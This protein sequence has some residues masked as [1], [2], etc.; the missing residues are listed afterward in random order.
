[1]AKIALV[2][3]STA[4]LTSELIEEFDVHVVPL[5]VNFGDE[6][7]AAHQLTPTEFYRRLASAEA[8]PTTSQ[9]APEDFMNIYNKLLE[10]YDEVISIHLST[11]LSG[12]LN[13]ARV[14]KDALDQA[15]IH[16]VDSRSISLGVA[17]MVQEAARGIREG[18]ASAAIVE[19]VGKV[20]QRT[21]TLFTL[22]TLE[23]L[24]KGGRIGKV[25]GLVGSLLNIK[26]II[27]VNDEGIYVPAGKARSQDRA[28]DCL[29][30]NFKQLANGRAAVQIAVAHGAAREAAQRLQTAMEE[31]FSVKASI[32]TEVGPVIGVHTGPGTVGVAVVFE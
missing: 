28:L 1:M 5:G 14:A 19:A 16:L 17:V 11:A 24:Q 21:E 32:F 20:R 18:L 9:P 10:K 31:A 4:D 12:T 7:F 13:A 30:K 6:Y 25:S 29:A 15:R 3:D 27:R 8:L 2:T 22:N 23:Y 26:P